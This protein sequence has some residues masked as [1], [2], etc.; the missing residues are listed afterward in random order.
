MEHGA[1]VDVIPVGE[2]QEM[3]LVWLERAGV[4]RDIQH[5]VLERRQHAHNTQQ[6][7][8]LPSVVS[9]TVPVDVIEMKQLSGQFTLLIICLSVSSIAIGPQR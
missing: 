6:H 4:L 3:A 8:H 5:V 2:M 7:H 1:A 9:I